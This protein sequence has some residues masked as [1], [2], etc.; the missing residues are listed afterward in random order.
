MGDKLFTKKSIIILGFILILGASVRLVP[1]F[2]LDYPL[3][4]GGFFT[5]LTQDLIDQNFDL[6]IYTTYNQSEIPFAYPPLSF[7]L[8]GFISRGFGFPIVEVLRLL[9]AILSILTIPIFFLLAKSLLTETES[10]F[11]SAAF[12]LMPT[13]FD[14]L[15]VGGGLSRAPAY[16]FAMLSLYFTLQFLRETTWKAVIF[17]SIFAGLTLLSHPGVSW[18]LTY[19]SLVLILYYQ[20]WRKGLRY[21]LLIW[22]GMIIVF[23]ALWWLPV[24]LRHGFSTILYPFQ[25]EGYSPLSLFVPFTLLFT[26]ETLVAIWAVAGL[27]GAVVRLQQKQYLILIWLVSVFLLEPRLSPTYA[28]IPYALLAGIGSSHF[29]QFLFDSK[30]SENNYAIGKRL[31]LGFIIIYAVVGAYL[32]IDYKTITSNDRLLME[33]IR[34]NSDQDS[35]FAIVTGNQA[36]GTDTIS[37]WF[38]V[39]SQRHSLSTPQ[40]YE[41]LPEQKFNHRVKIHAA[42]QSCWNRPISC[43]EEWEN[44]YSLKSTHI[45]LTD[46]NNVPYQDSVLW[47]SL[48]N[49]PD[50]KLI[51]QNNSGAVFNIYK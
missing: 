32:A 46:S 15:I 4:D 19:S 24:V 47:W 40:G 49:D 37:E 43:L 1:V 26:N 28:T 29:I 44:Q 36:Y 9:P 42:L 22:G 27:I 25:T 33:W 7:Y 3:N 2:T 35:E 21:H 31:F 18:F 10:I 41:W 51:F 30:T 11:A 48:N 38:P 34:T 8:A 20:G 5:Q 50:Y 6:P 39:I 17:S 45:Y 13:A 12:A 16:I 23:S 14:W